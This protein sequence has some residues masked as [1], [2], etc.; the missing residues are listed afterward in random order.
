[1]LLRCLKSI[2]YNGFAE[3][4]FNKLGKQQG[5]CRTL[6]AS[7]DRIS[8]LSVELPNYNIQMETVSHIEK[9]ELEITKARTVIESA[10][11]EKQAILDKY[12]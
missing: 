3:L 2:V 8:G 5:F 6:R 9:L 10:A 11:S 7:I 4:R 1:M 12:L